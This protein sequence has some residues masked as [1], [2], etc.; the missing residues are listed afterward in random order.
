MKPLL[1]RPAGPV[2]RQ[3]WTAVV[4]AGCFVV[5]A[6]ALALLPVPFVAW[7]P[8][9]TINLLGNNAEDA[10][11]VDVTRIKTYPVN[12]QLRM[13]TV[14][15]TRVDAQLSLPEALW[16]YWAPHRDVLL[17]ELVYSPN[18]SVEQVQ[19]DQ[20]AMMDT[21]KAD[22]VVAALRAAG[23]PVQVMPQV[24]S[25]GVGGPSYN[26]LQP[27]D[28][29]ERVDQIEVHQPKDVARIVSGHA[30]GDPVVLSVL[31]EQK[32]LDVTVTTV[33]S[34]A[35]RPSQAPSASPTPSGTTSPLARPVPVIGITTRDGYLFSPEVNY[36]IDPKVVGPSAGLVFSLAIYDK[37]TE[38][39]VVAG[40][41]IAGTGTIKADGD[42]GPIGGIQE[43]IAGADDAGSEIFLVPAEN[44]TDLG[45]V[46]TDMVLVKVD[47][48]SD[49]I[50]SLQ[51][52]A[53]DEKASVPSC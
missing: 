36:G 12:G 24:R 47:A 6:V 32:K 52:L 49:A 5:L 28:L 25:V 22:A 8:G 14:S 48:L 4:A 43:K 13:T 35:S 15:V 50:S 46:R 41:D 40:R 2:T 45:E 1:A 51:A 18:K 29:I 19:R 39:D 27:G 9:T 11:A 30:V 3:T 31:R 42:V 7:R 10:P 37:I 20:V 53:R 33:A 26:K 21:S 16:A 17:R 44:C 34:N 38:T 23:Q